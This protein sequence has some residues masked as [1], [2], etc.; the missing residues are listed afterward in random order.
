MNE[1]DKLLQELIDE[2]R[3]L[4]EELTI[5]TK[6][7]MTTREVCRFLGIKDPWVLTLM[8]RQGF[9]PSRYGGQSG[10]YKYSRAEVQITQAKL[11]SGEI[12][13]PKRSEKCAA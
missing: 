2:F 8:H 12:Q 11:L 1:T 4:R 10:G 7:T 13:L 9:L 6:T 3:L 5:N